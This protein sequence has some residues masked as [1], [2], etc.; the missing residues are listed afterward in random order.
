[1]VYDKLCF[2]SNGSNIRDANVTD[3]TIIA[4][5]AIEGG[6]KKHFLPLII[7][8]DLCRSIDIYVIMITAALIIEQHI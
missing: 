6:A 4:L 3:P 7:I 1:M 5:V 8:I 2:L